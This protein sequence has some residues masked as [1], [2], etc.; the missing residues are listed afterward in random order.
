MNSSI[1]R[2]F[3]LSDDYIIYH[4]VLVNYMFHFLT[5]KAMKEII[6]VATLQEVKRMIVDQN[7]ESKPRVVNVHCSMC[8]NCSGIVGD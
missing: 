4:P 1:T 8:A 6:G 2:N 7:C 3:I 5:I